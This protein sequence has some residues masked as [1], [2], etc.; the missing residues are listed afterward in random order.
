MQ[1]Q[2][3]PASWVILLSCPGFKIFLFFTSLSLP[4][5]NTR[6][7]F[8]ANETSTLCQNRSRW[9]LLLQQKPAHR[10]I[11]WKIFPFWVYFSGNQL[12]QQKFFFST[13]E[14]K[15]NRTP[16]FLADKPFPVFLDSIEQIPEQNGRVW[17][18]NTG[19]EGFAQCCTHT[20]ARTHA[21][22]ESILSRHS[23]CAI[24]VDC[25]PFVRFWL[26]NTVASATCTN[27]QNASSCELSGKQSDRNIKFYAVFPISCSGLPSG[28]NA[29]CKQESDQMFWP[30]KTSTA[31]PLSVV[32]LSTNSG[33]FGSNKTVFFFS[34][35]ERSVESFGNVWF[36]DA[37]PNFGD[38]GG[39]RQIPHSPVL[40]EG[41]NTIFGQIPRCNRNWS[42]T[43][44][45]PRIL[46][47]PEHGTVDKAG[48]QKP[49]VVYFTYG[50]GNEMT[51]SKWSLFWLKMQNE[52]WE[53][54]RF[55]FSW[56]ILV[57]DHSQNGLS[58][59][60]RNK[61]NA[62]LHVFDC[63]NRTREPPKMQSFKMN[64]LF[65]V[66]W[67]DLHP[68]KDLL[69]PGSRRVRKI[70]RVDGIESREDSLHLLISFLVKLSHA[71][72]TAHPTPGG[73]TLEISLDEWPVS[74][75]LKCRAG[76]VFV[77]CR[78]C[79]GMANHLSRNWGFPRTVARIVEVV[80]MFCFLV[81]YSKK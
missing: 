77:Q 62:F 53:P 65:G 71:V 32:I 21:R 16:Y 35:N 54:F 38:D 58:A 8:S 34:V 46:L 72:N 22:W 55:L 52:E 40:F 37:K 9:T 23:C 51:L 2:K 69:L 6:K 79:S 18:K 31:C 57:R 81:F 45:L 56:P 30:C 80:F 10:Q 67:S 68:R 28:N 47:D 14:Q 61:L 66:F 44:L 39:N 7:S 73:V 13:R 29:N 64:K 74:R 75:V 5:R 36:R 33:C 70:S 26:H 25:C 60:N 48:L 76:S 49:I 17:V 4:K 12:N 15:Q 78:R 27:F 43:W 19:P 59:W 11:L 3:D 20:H 50:N 24:F 42:F 41:K 1:T 63:M